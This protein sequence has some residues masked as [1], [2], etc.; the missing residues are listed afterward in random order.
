VTR[1][2]GT[3]AI[4]LVAA[5]AAV[6]GGVAAVGIG[7]AAGW[8]GGGETIVLESADVGAPQGQAIPA[9]D[10]P[11][12][13]PGD[14]FDPEAV[15]RARSAGVV[16]IYA[17]FP[18]HGE[19]EATAQAQGS[20]FVASADGYIL[21]NSHV[22][23]TAGEES[24]TAG[25]LAAE[26]IYVE[27]RDGDR[28]AAEI[29][30]WDVF[31]DVGLVRVDPTAHDLAPLPLGDSGEV[32]V[33]EPVAAIGSPFG[34]V[35]SLTVG[36]VSATQRAVDSLTSEYSVVDAIQ[37]DAPINR[38]NS[39][40]PLFNARGEVI[41]VNAQIRSDSG[42]SEGVGFA[43]PINSA[44]RSM[45]QLVE[46]GHVRYAWVGISTQTVTPSM[47]RVLDLGVD[48][49]AAIQTVVAGSPAERAGLRAG[50][51]EIFLQ[52]FGFLRGGDVVVA[53]DGQEVASTE[54]LIRVVAGRLFPGQTAQF[55]ILRDGALL[56]VE[57]LLG[58]RPANPDA[59]R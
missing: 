53:I 5:L 13:L 28:V 43:I 10:G 48:G 41:G 27:F 23:T 14:P 39:G 58:D 31:N 40:G 54:D 52:G 1:R 57:V 32:A 42:S 45:E 47:A 29:V 50:T 26:E 24:A 2:R 9:A 22:I 35:S 11:A 15:Y 37:T 33:G 46:S 7:T 34:Q 59:G 3:A 49:G 17:L 16:T 44:R 6:A 21:T 30:G 51:E 4:A 56:T 18:G 12:P 36:V 8:L 20:G 55:G 25:V 19:G 38:G